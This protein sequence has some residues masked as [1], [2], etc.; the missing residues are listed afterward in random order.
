MGSDLDDRLDAVERALTDSDRTPES[1][2]EAADLAD[3]LDDLVARVADLESRA[4][5]QEAALR[6][7]RGYVGNV[8]HV[9]R[10]VERT[11]EAALAKAR[12]LDAP[13]ADEDPLA[14]IETA[15]AAGATEQE[16]SVHPKE[17]TDAD[18]DGTADARDVA[19]HL[20]GL[21]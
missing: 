3:R 12:A 9:N 19:D 1:L 13:D 10:E 7:V 2:P 17:A 5:D 11:A 4:D 6:A 14:G 21:L 15:D 20:R 18:D 8:R 16:A